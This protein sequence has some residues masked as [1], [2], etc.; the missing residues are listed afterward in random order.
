MMKKD[1]TEWRKKFDAWKNGTPTSELFNLSKYDEGTDDKTY[2][3]EYEYEATVTPQGTS[4]EKH[5]RITN[6]E[7]WQK[8]WGNVGA[9]YVN[10][11]QESVAK[12]ALERLKTASYFTPLGNATALGD[13][14]AA[15][16]NGDK[17]EVLANAAGLLPQVRWAK[18][19]NKV[20]QF[21]NAVPEKSSFK[22]LKDVLNYPIEVVAARRAGR[23]PLTFSERRD[24]VK[25]LQNEATDAW[26]NVQ[27]M[28]DALSS[29]YPKLFLPGYRIKRPKTIIGGDNI[30]KRA[31]LSDNSLG[32]Y[33][34]RSG[35]VVLRRRELGSLLPIE[36]KYGFKGLSAH[37]YQHAVRDYDSYLLEEP[38]TFSTEVDYDKLNPNFTLSP[39]FKNVITPIG[40]SGKNRT[41]WQMSPDEFLSDYWKYRAASDPSGVL[42]PPF[43][44]MNDLQKNEVVDF[45]SRRF[46]LSQQTVRD[47]LQDISFFG[48]Y[49]KG[50]SIHINPANRGK[51]KATM[52]RTGKSAEEL[53]HSKNPLTRKRAIFALNSRKFK[54]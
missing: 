7:D 3:P 30:V 1:P 26:Y 15:N 40:A 12:P 4:L 51:F 9:G 19:I 8:Y 49:D 37:E 34:S 25:L 17:D 46:D 5:K 18:G 41:A 54:H 16:I 52:K 45:I 36:N 2:L 29:E 44:K 50:K 39:L 43:H 24:Y 6:E 21:F 31:G 27:D 22:L 35:D 23:Y 38:F 42:V 33:N 11:A 14:L 47:A 48:G 10:K 53:S 32:H 20:A 28:Q 13:F